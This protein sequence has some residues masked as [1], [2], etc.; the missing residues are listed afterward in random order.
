MKVK[1]PDSGILENLTPGINP[2]NWRVHNDQPLNLIGVDGGVGVRHHIADVV[3]NNKC[4]VVSQRCHNGAHIFGLSLL[5]I[6]TVGLGG[7]PNAAEVR[8]HYRMV[9]HEVSGEWS[10]RIAVFRVSMDEKHH[11]SASSP[12]Y[13]NVRPFRAVDRLCLKARRQG[14]LCLTQNRGEGEKGHNK[15]TSDHGYL[16][17]RQQ[18]TC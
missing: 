9:L 13:K 3:S 8:H 2:G 5:V 6:A 17:I 18:S 12:T 11:G 1:V 4:L 10:P 14:G 16:R 15:E 7:S